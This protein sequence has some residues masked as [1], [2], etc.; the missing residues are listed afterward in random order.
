MLLLLLYAS[1]DI[2]FPQ[3]WDVSGLG[4]RI[5]LL[6]LFVLTFGREVLLVFC[7][8]CVLFSEMLSGV[9]NDLMV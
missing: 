6:N 3:V 5:I 2:V 9:V 7:F 1:A 4:R 8:L